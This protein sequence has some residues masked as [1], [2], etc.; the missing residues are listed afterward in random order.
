MGT[1]QFL[2][3]PWRAVFASLSEG[4]NAQHK[5]SLEVVTALEI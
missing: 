5:H 2:P 3:L 4:W 1:Q